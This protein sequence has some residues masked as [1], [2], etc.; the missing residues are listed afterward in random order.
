MRFLSNVHRAHEFYQKLAAFEQPTDVSSDVSGSFQTMGIKNYKI[1]CLRLMRTLEYVSA[2]ALSIYDS[3]PDFWYDS[4][5]RSI[6][7]QLTSFVRFVEHRLYRNNVVKAN[8]NVK[9]DVW[10]LEIITASAYISRSCE[11]HFIL[12]LFVLHIAG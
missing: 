2:N 11:N 10:I 1:L 8:V 4:G 6:E 12:L 7:S 5:L 9:S 3:R